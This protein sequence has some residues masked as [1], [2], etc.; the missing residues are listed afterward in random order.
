MAAVFFFKSIKSGSRNKC[1]NKKYLVMREK[2]KEHEVLIEHIS[3]ELMI[4]DPITK[5]LP[6]KQY[7]KHVDH[8][9]LVNPFDI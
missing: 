9:G 8:I 4:A 7:R 3:T 1:I 2:M 5:A 6:T